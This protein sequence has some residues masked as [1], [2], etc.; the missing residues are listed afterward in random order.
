MY[1]A[2]KPTY[3]KRSGICKE[4]GHTIEKNTPCIQ[5]KFKF[6]EHWNPQHFHLACAVAKLEHWFV[7]NPPTTD[8]TCGRRRKSIFNVKRRKLISLQIYHK[9]Q[10]NTKRVEELEM[11]IKA[12]EGA[13]VE[14]S[15]PMKNIA[16]CLHCKHEV[17]FYKDGAGVPH[18]PR[19][20]NIIGTQPNESAND[21]AK[22]L[23]SIQIE[24]QIN[25]KEGEI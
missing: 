14:K 22:G 15:E 5:M 16:M 3:L 1:K 12:L 11:Q 17:L 25:N 20:R 18:C 6:G 19:C 24:K 13:N 10:G 8:S 7:M 21:V 23:D 9:K 4:C 2:M